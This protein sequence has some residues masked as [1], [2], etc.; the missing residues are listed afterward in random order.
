MV[1][2]DEIEPRLSEFA[3]GSLPAGE[4]EDVG[5]HLDGCERCAGVVRDLDRLRTAAR[6]LGPMT[7]PAH[8]WRTLERRL[9]VAE[10]EQTSPVPSRPRRSVA[11]WAGIAAAVT[12]VAGSTYVGFR[13]GRTAPVPSAGTAAESPSTAADEV[14]LAMTHYD[15]A[16]AGLQATAASDISKMDPGLAATLQKNLGLIDAAIAESRTA[17]TSDPASAAARDSLLEALQQKVSVLQDTV[18]LANDE[19]SPDPPGGRSK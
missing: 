4:R 15:T 17:L 2:C 9:E 10:T 18:T 5:R 8:V 16:I 6:N 7:P 1:T 11:R 13:H 3:D 19:R 14:A 12:L